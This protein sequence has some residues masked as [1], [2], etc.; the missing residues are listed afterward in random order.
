MIDLRGQVWWTEA[1]RA[2]LDAF[3]RQ[4]VDALFAHR[5]CCETCRAGYPPC[6]VVRDAI[7][8]VVEWRD[9]RALLSLAA[10]LRARQDELEAGGRSV[11]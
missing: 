11:A 4:L 8:K 3:G 10:A 6:P 7:E 5:A 2:E 1:D 9:L